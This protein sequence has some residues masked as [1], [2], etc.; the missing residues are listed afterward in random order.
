MN[1]QKKNTFLVTVWFHYTYLYTSFK[2]IST[3]NDYLNQEM[4]IWNNYQNDIGLYFV[5][6]FFK[7]T[8]KKYVRIKRWRKKKYNIVVS[9]YP[10][11]E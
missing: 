4:I 2:L 9:V 5:H 11:L 1:L 6:V 7:V 8:S 3:R 10:V